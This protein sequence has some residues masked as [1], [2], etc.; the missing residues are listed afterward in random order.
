MNE[1]IIIEISITE[2]RRLIREEVVAALRGQPTPMVERSAPANA[3]GDD[4]APEMYSLKQV[5]ALSGLS[6]PYLRLKDKSGDLRTVRFGKVVRVR[7]EDLDSFL[8]IGT[9]PQ[10][11]NAA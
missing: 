3:D 10:T 11:R 6:M 1:K 2:F 5:A 7:K 9:E 4:K 8:R